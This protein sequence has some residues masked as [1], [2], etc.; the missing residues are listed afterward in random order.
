MQTKRHT[1]AS[2]AR[3]K[4]FARRRRIHP[5]TALLLAGVGVT[6]EFV[7]SKHERPGYY[8]ANPKWHV[9]GTK[10]ISAKRPERSRKLRGYDA[11]TVVFD[12]LSII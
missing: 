9:Q 7:P 3:I 6:H 2:I 10:G 5:R 8:G 4:D 12:E 11:T 1:P